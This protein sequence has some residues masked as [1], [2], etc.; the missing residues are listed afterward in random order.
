M[1]DKIEVMLEPGAKLPHRAH[2]NDAGLDLY[3][4]KGIVV[5][6][7][8]TEV[9]DTGV[10]V[11]IPPGY[12]G[13]IVARSSLL[14]RGI[15]CDGTIDAGYTGTIKVILINASYDPYRVYSGDRIAQ[16]IIEPIET[17]VPVV[18]ESFPETERGDNGI[19]ST[20]S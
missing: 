3:S 19:G 14:A 11:R 1:L 13:R 8:C 6:P 2:P 18:V 9:I 10:H 15:L 17:P 7:C 16:L 20:G 12:Y 5:V 4:P